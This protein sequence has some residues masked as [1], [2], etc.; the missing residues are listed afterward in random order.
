MEFERNLWA[1]FGVAVRI[2]GAEEYDIL[3]K[4]SSSL[5]D[6][7]TNIIADGRCSLEGESYI[8]DICVEDFD[9]EYGTNYSGEYTAETY[10]PIQTRDELG[11]D[12]G[13]AGAPATADGKRCLWVCVGATM[14]INSSEESA[15]LRGDD[16]AVREAFARIFEERRYKL[17]G[18]TFIPDTSIADFNRLY[19]TKYP[20]CEICA[21]F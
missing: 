6:V 18:E 20:D 17:D 5:R 4:E 1:R 3:G 12:D 9:S 13:S 15:I 19:G 8:P 14:H 10:F 2:T 21:N 7:L 11:G 16:A